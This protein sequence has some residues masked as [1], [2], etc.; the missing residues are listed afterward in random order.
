MKKRWAEREEKWL[1][2]EER[3][4]SEKRNISFFPLPSLLYS[5][6][7]LHHHLQTQTSII[8]F[9]SVQLNYKLL[10]SVSYSLSIAMIRI[11]VRIRPSSLCHSD[12]D[13]QRGRERKQELPINCSGKG[14]RR[15][16]EREREL[17]MEQMR[18]QEQSWGL[19]F[20]FLSPS[21]LF[22]CVGADKNLM[23]VGKDHHHHH[24]HHHLTAS[25]SSPACL[26]ELDPVWSRLCGRL[27][28]G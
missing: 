20:F 17:E 14:K 27:T 13:R 28:A 11:D 25:L 4:C 3:L 1:P 2:P 18:W 10:Y 6:T 15:E 16:R 8:S 23:N 7:V 12:G 21:C 19:F 5:P 24:H 26:P 9:L 22:C